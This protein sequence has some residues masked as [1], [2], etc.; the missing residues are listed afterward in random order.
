MLNELYLRRM[1]SSSCASLR[2]HCNSS[3][4]SACNFSGDWRASDREIENPE[5][6]LVCEAKDWPRVFFD[7]RRDLFRCFFFI[8][9]YTNCRTLKEE[10][11]IQ[12]CLV[13]YTLL[14][15]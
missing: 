6:L 10:I 12:V 9:A 14:R 13:H 3:S 4:L 11:K 1:A 15:F 5:S 8:T 7:R 2:I